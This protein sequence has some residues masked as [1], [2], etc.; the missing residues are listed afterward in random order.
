M[1]GESRRRGGKIRAKAVKGGTK[2]G[3]APKGTDK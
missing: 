3:C 1:D 2:K